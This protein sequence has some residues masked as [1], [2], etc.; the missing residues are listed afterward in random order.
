MR[1]QRCNRGTEAC[2]QYMSSLN[3][4]ESASLSSMKKDQ[5]RPLM[6]KRTIT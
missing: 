6:E 1:I 5:K 2:R 4:R 3:V